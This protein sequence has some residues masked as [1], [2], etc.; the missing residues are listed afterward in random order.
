VSTFHPVI[1]MRA[2]VVASVGAALALSALASLSAA[3]PRAN[4]AQMR[5]VRAP[6]AASVYP[7]DYLA[8][9]SRVDSVNR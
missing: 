6:I 3:P 7:R 2:A 1:P 8:I 5:P 9:L 4:V